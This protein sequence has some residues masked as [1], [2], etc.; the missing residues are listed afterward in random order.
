M[1]E[2]ISLD[3]FKSLYNSNPTYILDTNIY[4]NLLRYS[5]KS[6]E[7]LLSI[8]KILQSNIW[9][10]AQVNLEFHNNLSIVEGQRVANAKKA[11]TEVK[12]SINA[13][14][15]SIVKQLNFFI[16]YK[17][18]QSQD[19]VSKVTTDLAA[20]KKSIEDY[21]KTNVESQ[22]S[23]FLDKQDIID[24]FTFV[25]NFSKKQELHPSKLFTIY[26]D[27]DIRYKYKIPPGYMDDP[28]NNSDSAKDGVAI[29]GDLI[30]WNEILNY[31]KEADY[32]IIF[33]TSD[34]KEDWFLLKN[35]KP[36]APRE[37][38]LKEFSEQTNAN[39][40][41]ILT[42]EKFIEYIG[43][44]LLVDNALILAEMQKDD[45]ADVAIRNNKD[46]IKKEL[47]RW[48]NSKEHIDLVPF[49]SEINRITEIEDFTVIIQDVAVDVKDDAYY[50][51]NFQ[52][53]AEFVGAYYD[54]NIKRFTLSDQRESFFFKVNVSFRR[55]RA[56]K[57]TSGDIFS[58]DVTDII[59]KSG[60]F[61]HCILDDVSLQSK[62]GVFIKPNDADH[63]IYSYIMSIW[64][65]Y[66]EK[67][68]RDR[69]EAL[70]Y[71]DAAKY[72]NCPLLE[73]NRAFMLVENQTTKINLSLNEIDVLA[74]KRLKDIGFKIGEDTCTFDNTSVTLGKAYPIPE[75][76][77]LL[78][79]DEGK[80]L[81][82][83]FTYEVI[84][85]EGKYVQIK[86]L[87]TLPKDTN[88]MISLV[89]KELKY[90]ASSSVT[91]TDYGRF[92]S[93]IFKKGSNPNNNTIPNGQ[94]KLEIV[95]PIVSTQPDTVKVAFGKMG[96]NL[97]GN[98]VS[99]DT[100]MGNTVNFTETF[101]IKN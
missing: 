83:D 88:L 81:Q 29:F 86:G 79:P 65:K 28:R 6:S 74:L 8:Y 18:D 48:I 20:L 99:N 95:V 37:E 97:V 96:R 89:N 82:V 58:K 85:H 33:V 2:F 45:F 25:Y 13:C 100:I 55:A 64:G 68:N 31:G 94:Y 52:A 57:N 38:L 14:N 70:V 35:E 32:P 40:I 71:I 4:L 87:T 5:K 67:N 61:E 72:F 51:V 17:F 90:R 63:E 21:S 15:Q 54:E 76:M 75:S 42:S 53:T 30:L 27:G 39:Q 3:A 84:R 9:I 46:V 34:V 26:K 60:E 41:S 24:F 73:I 80:K 10:P 56:K 22:N 78:T 92:Q 98:Y 43:D 1:N 69:T 59:I 77:V 16:R 44:I 93:E 50:V 62:R 91:V 12:K 7:D 11:I 19:I 47:I 36:I 66:Q 101:E 49:V 23:G